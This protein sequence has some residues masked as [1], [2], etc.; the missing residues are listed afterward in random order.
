MKT[1]YN[2]G[3]LD[4]EDMLDTVF[5]VGCTLIILG[6]FLRDFLRNDIFNVRE[7]LSARDI[8]AFSNAYEWNGVGFPGDPS[9][10]EFFIE[11]ARLTGDNAGMVGKLVRL[12]AVLCRD[13]VGEVSWSLYVDLLWLIN[14]LDFEPG[15]SWG[16]FSLS[17]LISSAKFLWKT[18]WI[19]SISI[20]VNIT[21]Y[22]YTPSALHGM[23][24][25]QSWPV[26]YEFPNI[27]R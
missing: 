26:Y 24:S 14:E 10:T 17:C 7:R 9:I 1:I 27:V 3:L 12:A 19:Q 23:V 13:R 11:N 16:F 2:W 21:F 25:S 8:L 6:N 4:D 5:V 18:M 15:L 22:A 20:L